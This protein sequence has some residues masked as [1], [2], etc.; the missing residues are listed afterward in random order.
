MEL[1]I[2]G[3]TN[4]ADARFAAAAGADYLGFIQYAGSPRYVDASAV[5]EIIEWVFGPR[6]VGVF[7]DADAEHI[8]ET[9]RAA[10]F[11]LVQLHGN[12]SVET[13]RAV[14]LPIIKAF[15]VT[16]SDQ[17]GDLRERMHAYVG[18]ARYFLLDTH[19]DTRKGGTGKAFD[20]T[21]AHVLAQ[22]FPI[23]LAGGIN[24]QNATEACRVVEPYGLDVSS[25]LE[26]EPGQKDYPKV[27]AFF[28]ALR[29]GGM[30]ERNE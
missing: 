17:L 6:T 19:D 21:L 9:A 3:I 11:D 30:F 8:N 14:H 15:R 24:P 2:C 26:S 12:E 23:F 22:E 27:K 25:G 28:A 18:V 1:K 20:W 13:C 4:L 29:T 10:G 5:A 7:V 16:E